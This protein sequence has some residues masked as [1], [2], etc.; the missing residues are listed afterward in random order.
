MEELEGSLISANIQT[1]SNLHFPQGNET[2]SLQEGG[3]GSDLLDS[4]DCK[5]TQCQ[6]LMSVISVSYY[7]YAL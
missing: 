2:S 6:P 1:N 3:G 4:R 7:A 5:T